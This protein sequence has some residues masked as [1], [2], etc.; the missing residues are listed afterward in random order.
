VTVASGVRSGVRSGVQS[1]LNPGSYAF[2]AT[3]PGLV[4][5]AGSSNP[6]GIIPATDNTDV[7]GIEDVYAGFQLTRVGA[8]GGAGPTIVASAKAGLQPRVDSLGGSYPAGTAGAELQ[9]GRDLDAA[10]ANAWGGVAFTSDG[11]FLDPGSANGWLNGSYP[12]TPPSWMERFFA[13][14]DA[15]VIAH[16][17]PFRV[18]IWDHGNDGNIA[19]GA[20]YYTNLVT[21]MDRVRRRYGNV[22]IVV[23]I[24]TNKNTAGGLMQTVRAAMESFAMRDDSARVRTVYIDDAALI[25][26]A[27]IGPNAGGAIGV[28]TLG[29]RYATAVISAANNTVDNTSPK[30]GA[31]GAVVTATSLGLAPVPLPSFFGTYNNKRD[32][33]VLWYSGAS[34]N[35]I[36]APTGWTQVTNSPQFAGAV[37]DSRLHVFTRVLQPG[38]AA[39]TIA[40]VASDEA[41]LAGIFVIRNSSGLDVNPTGDTVA[42]AAASADV[43]WPDLTPVTANCLIVQLVAYRIDDTVSKCSGYTNAALAGLAERVDIDSNVGSGY[44]IAVCVGTKATAAAIGNTTATLAAACS[45]A[46]LTLCFKP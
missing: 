36:T 31:Q 8:L 41:K 38:D 11:S 1:G 34:A 5:I 16:G 18:L 17:K 12:T 37:A 21:F 42:A 35:A 40:D 2:V 26:A 14:I 30:W 15:A 39:P 32:I 10:N 28:C 22:G 29:S 45:Q 4:V 7:P 23:P 20:N 6:Q 43:T 24:L 25:D 19:A 9:M 44:G 13:A 33:G 3:G 27:H 46:R